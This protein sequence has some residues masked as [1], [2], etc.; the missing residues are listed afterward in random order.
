MHITRLAL[1]DLSDI[2]VMVI[3][4]A[5]PMALLVLA[6]R[7]DMSDIRRETPRSQVAFWLHVIAAYEL[8]NRATLFLLGPDM[9]RSGWEMIDT[10]TT[11]PVSQTAIGFFLALVTG[12]GVLALALDRRA[13]L[14]TGL[15]VAGPVLSKAVPA[16]IA[17]MGI[18]MSALMVALG[19]Q[20]ARKTVLQ[21]LPPLV[22]AQLPR[23]ALSFGRSRPVA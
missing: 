22:A 2:T 7:W 5:V 21:L 16:P 19:W 8:V 10:I 3:V 23:T 17:M 4:L 13:L 18:G 14:I 1:P 11:G 12:L 6:I 15:L 9:R 20:T